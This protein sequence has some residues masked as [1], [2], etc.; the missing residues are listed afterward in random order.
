M[1]LDSIYYLLQIS[2]TPEGWVAAWLA[3]QFVEFV[4]ERLVLAIIVQIFSRGKVSDP[5]H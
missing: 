2:E 1:K 4:D 3:R 5:W